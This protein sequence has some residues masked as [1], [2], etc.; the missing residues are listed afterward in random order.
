[1]PLRF[2][3]RE[4]DGTKI[5]VTGET[6]DEPRHMLP[7]VD[8]HEFPRLSGVDRFGTTVFNGL[9]CQQLT[10]ELSRLRA[11]RL[12]DEQVRLLDAIEALCSE[13]AAQPHRLL[14]VLGD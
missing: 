8:D 2:E 1:M 10:N 6:Y 5:G 11:V 9:Q 3:A 12:T 14:W 13:V 4:A 7:A